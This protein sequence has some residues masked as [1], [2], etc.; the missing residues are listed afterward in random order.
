MG[1]IESGASKPEGALLTDG[2]WRDPRWITFSGS[3]GGVIMIVVFLELGLVALWIACGSGRQRR[4]HFWVRVALASLALPALM[5]VLVGVARLNVLSDDAA[6]A[7]LPF[8]FFLG[9]VA[10]MLLPGLLYRRSSSS[11][12]PSDSDGGGGPGPGQ[13]RSSPDVPRG[14]VPL[15]DADQASARAR[16]HNTPKFDDPK[17]RRPAHE[18]RRAPARTNG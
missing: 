15:P 8:L 18:P 9:V 16:D 12:G 1:A 11:L 13:P 7:I 3:V 4:S 5:A 6:K 2:L 17:W 10:L 14:G